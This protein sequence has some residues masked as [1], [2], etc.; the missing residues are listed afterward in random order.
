MSK[1]MINNV[2]VV[3]MEFAV[4]TRDFDTNPSESKQT[5]DHRVVKPEIQC[6][7]IKSQL[8]KK[9]KKKTGL[10]YLIPIIAKRVWRYLP[11]IEWNKLFNLNSILQ[12]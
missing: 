10:K 9:K 4:E 8:K 12:M 5:I 3:K 6:S 1:S 7:Y 11:L 2:N